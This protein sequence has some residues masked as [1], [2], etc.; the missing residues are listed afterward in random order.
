MQ[1][2]IDEEA[3]TIEKEHLARIEGERR[4]ALLTDDLRA[5]HEEE[6][7]NL[8]REHRERMEDS[9]RQV[10]INSRVREEIAAEGEKVRE[11]HRQ[12]L[13]REAKQK[14]LDDDMKDKIQEQADQLAREHKERRRAEQSIVFEQNTLKNEV[15]HMEEVLTEEKLEQQTLAAA[16]ERERAKLDRAIHLAQA[17]E[18]AQ[19][20]TAALREKYLEAQIA[21][22]VTD[23]ALYAEQVAS[24]EVE[25][26]VLARAAQGDGIIQGPKVTIA[27]APLVMPGMSSRTRSMSPK[28]KHAP[29]TSATVAAGA[30]QAGDAISVNTLNQA[31]QGFQ[32]AGQGQATIVPPP[33]APGAS[34][35]SAMQPQNAQ[36]LSYEPPMAGSPSRQG[37]GGDSRSRPS[38]VIPTSTRAASLRK[39]SSHSPSR[40]RDARTRRQRL[41]AEA[42]ERSV[43]VATGDLGSVRSSRSRGQSVLSRKDQIARDNARSYYLHEQQV[44]DLE[45]G[46]F[47]PE[48]NPLLA[49]G[50]DPKIPRGLRVRLH[51]ATAI[52]IA[53]GGLNTPFNTD[54]SGISDTMIT[55]DGQP[56]KTRFL[57]P[58]FKRFPQPG[59]D[60]LVQDRN[61]GLYGEGLWLPNRA[62]L[63]SSVPVGSSHRRA[64]QF[65]S[66]TGAGAGGDAQP[67]LTQAALKAVS[68]ASTAEAIGESKGISREPLVPPQPTTSSAPSAGNMKA[69]VSQLMSR[70]DRTANADTTSSTTSSHPPTV[71][72]VSERPHRA[73]IAPAD[74]IKGAAVRVTRLASKKKGNGT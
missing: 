5:Q 46:V 68:E 63:P 1:R 6:A 22:N 11:E 29:M 57:T 7:D 74:H 51:P 21:Q 37:G 59:D 70:M 71:E 36:Y 56:A 55:Y 50:E 43:E 34:Y 52:P 25:A 24:A 48:P 42:L 30:V 66:T 18:Q 16:Q 4:Q 39:A 13:E 58:Y 27:P 17:H 12:R 3:R 53:A 10:A 44:Q 38:I 31:I 40:S 49:P 28:R 26:A 62:S 65:T 69:L 33:A 15:G 60:Q 67:K 32:S 47:N 20:R 35:D 54:I 41:R 23:M 61:R 9:H 2:R 73:V 8:A 64:V 19:A 72:A 45:A 14:A